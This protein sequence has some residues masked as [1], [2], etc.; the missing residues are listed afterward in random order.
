MFALLLALLSIVLFGC[1]SLLNG[2]AI[3]VSVSKSN[4]TGSVNPDFYVVFEDKSAIKTFE[5]VIR[6][7]VKYNGIVNI[8]K[9]DYDFEIVYSSGNKRGF[10]LWL[11]DKGQKSTLLHTVDTHT[12]YTIS[13]KMTDKLI[14]LLNNDHQT[15]KQE[16]PDVLRMLGLQIDDEQYAGLYIDD[17][18]YHINIVGDA[19][20]FKDKEIADGVQF[21]S[22]N[23]SLQHLNEVAEVLRKNMQ[24]LGI[25]MIA[26]NEKDNKVDVYIKGLD[27]HKRMRIKNVIDSPAIEAKEQHLELKF[28]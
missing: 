7:S 4:G 28:N 22:V 11:G 14:E 3:K 24:N 23:Y 2:K 1:N 10:H 6:K 16:K 12:I 5:A 17:G 20:D 26:I 18:I 21:H 9:P 13:A 27:D 19:A 15:A 25:S 8:V